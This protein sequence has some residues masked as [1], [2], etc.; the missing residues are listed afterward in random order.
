M[1][2]RR[3]QMAR[4]SSALGTTICR[5]DRTSGRKAAKNCR[6]NNMRSISVLLLGLVALMTGCERS[7]APVMKSS[8]EVQKA[9]PRSGVSLSREDIVRL[10]K[11]TMHPLPCAQAVVQASDNDGGEAETIRARAINAWMEANIRKKPDEFTEVASQRSGNG[12]DGS[13]GWRGLQQSYAHSEQEYD[14]GIKTYWS[15]GKAREWRNGVL[16]DWPWEHA[17]LTFCAATPTDIEILDQNGDPSVGYVGVRYQVNWVPTNFAKQVAASDL[18]FLL[19]ELP[20][21]VGAASLRS[22]GPHQWSV[23]FEQ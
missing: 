10:L 13:V 5:R 14:L 2:S 23:T 16:D 18:D 3:G 6:R 9:P 17:S 8:G 12:W 11:Q 22:T 7:S 4:S 20:P 1:S 19:P 21:R 15:A